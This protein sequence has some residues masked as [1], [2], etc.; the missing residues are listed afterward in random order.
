MG[1]IRTQSIKNSI[2]LY[3]GIIIGAVNT[4]LVFPFVFE[5]NPEYWGLLQL[6]VSYSIVISSFS[7]L[8]SPHILIRYFP[9]FKNKDE[10]I[11]FLFV[12]CLFG[13][14]LFSSSFFLLKDYLL[15]TFDF[16][17]LFSE[18]FHLL[19]GFVFSLM[20]FDLFN[21][22]SRSY[23]D[24]TTPIF[25]NEVYLRIITLFLLV[26][27]HF[28][29]IDFTNFLWLYLFSYFS[30]LV[31]LFII[32]LFKKQI[33]LCFKWG[34]V[35]FNQIRYGLY[36]ILGSGAA[37]LVSRID[38][39]MIDYF[40]D[41]KHV[42]Y[43]GLAFF[44]GSVIKVPG[45][46]LSSISTPLISKAFEENDT[47]QI[48]QIYKK[49]SINLLVISSL[50]FLVIWLNIDEML[51]ILPEKF[52]QGKYVVLF[53]GLSQVINLS[54][55]LNGLIIINSIYFRKDILFNFILL[56][57][58]VLTN[59]LF[60]PIYGIDG[61]ALASLISIFFHNIIKII[62][63]YSK[64]KI[65]PFSFQTVKVLFISIG[66][67]FLFQWIPTFDNFILSIVV[68]TILILLT[69]LPLLILMNISS[70]VNDIYNTLK[71][72]LN[73]LLR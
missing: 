17:P 39:I 15:S 11:T 65:Q 26:A 9:K 52:Q 42:A 3:I 33:R 19:V 27:Y 67:Y 34:G 44:I 40:L 18:N 57:F 25:L 54:S 66:I 23:L 10:L 2:N 30:K 35:D 68:K 29:L 38:M 36:V 61:A 20:F 6:L 53:I 58:I 64:M 51:S 16:S 14:I 4:I 21:S 55:G 56:V 71:R 28:S 47:N 22:V 72:K 48:V 31:F 12:L 73:E 41:L 62:F 70:D 13:F 45:R 24:S 63:L 8:G 43:Y 46:S 7:H 37:I 50:M 59:I 5:A 60:I 69:F 1:I 32:Q 49:T